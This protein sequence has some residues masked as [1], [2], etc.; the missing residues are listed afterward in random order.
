MAAE[1]LLGGMGGNLSS[2]IKDLLDQFLTDTDPNSV[3]V[4]DLGNG[5]ALVIGK[6]EHGETQGAIVSGDVRVATEIKDGVMWL[7]VKLPSGVNIAF[8]GL[9]EQKTP[10]EIVD[11]LNSKIEEALPSS[12]S[13]PAVQALN[14]SLTNA[15]NNLIDGLVASGVDQSVLCIIDFADISHSL[16]DIAAETASGVVD[17]HG[18][19]ESNEIELEALSGSADNEVFA[20]LLNSIQEGKTLELKGIENAILVGSGKVKVGDDTDVN[21]Q[22]DNSDQHITGGSGN[23]TL[24]GGGGN[25]TLLGGDGDDVIGFNAL[26]HYTVQI[27][28][29]DKLAFQFDNIQTVADILP[30]VT[31]I[32]EADGNVTFEF[33]DGEASIT[34]VGMSASEITDDMVIFN[35]T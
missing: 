24:V 23:D 32:S 22:G 20:L 2:E 25:D 6:G 29:G 27:D 7:A 18:S 12:S 33:L 26:G 19:A 1:S 16:S 14:A 4:T 9:S 28:N 17:V 15:L 34:L 13:D 35:L 30:F 8:E 11:Y 31:N 5:A 3:K 21:L 10:A